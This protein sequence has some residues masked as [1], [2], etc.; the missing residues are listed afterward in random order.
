MQVCNRIYT[1]NLKLWRLPHTTFIKFS[2]IDL[3]IPFPTSSQDRVGGASWLQ[4]MDSREL[5]ETV[6]DL[7]QLRLE[8]VQ[9]PVTQLLD[10]GL[11]EQI[12]ALQLGH[13]DS[14]GGGTGIGTSTS[15]GWVISSYFLVW[16]CH[17][18]LR[19]GGHAFCL[20]SN[21]IRSRRSLL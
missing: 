4:L 18:Q 11:A 16:V 3:S 13:G 15:C 17:S 10:C 20:H 14:G 19:C 1:H 12:Q 9:K 2:E 7:Q 8:D 5:P 21:K 6:L